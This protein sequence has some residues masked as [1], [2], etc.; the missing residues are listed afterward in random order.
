MVGMGRRCQIPKSPPPQQRGDSGPAPARPAPPLEG[1]PDSRLLPPW[2]AGD[3]RCM[4]N[5][6]WEQRRAGPDGRVP[7]APT[8]SPELQ[9]PAPHVSQDWPRDVPARPPRLGVPG[10]HWD[11][12]IGAWAAGE[13]SFTGGTPLVYARTHIPPNTHAL[14]KHLQPHARS[15]RG[16]ERGSPTPPR[17][18]RR[19]ERTGTCWFSILP[20]PSP[21]KCPNKAVPRSDHTPHPGANG[22]ERGSRWEPAPTARWAGNATQTGGK[23][24]KGLWAA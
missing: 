3:P 13:K 5:G 21:P 11:R 6:G 8:Y 10:H 12:E 9:C 14:A 7:A 22:R 17:A 1:F 2:A 18:S 20:T 16:A 15:R 4:C 24:C 19:P 23:R